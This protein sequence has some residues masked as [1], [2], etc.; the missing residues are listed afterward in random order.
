MTKIEA[1]IRGHLLEKVHHALEAI[2]VTG[3]TVSDV[4]GMGASKGVHYLYRGAEYTLTLNPRLKL[5]VI[6]NDSQVAEVVEAIQK[7]ASTGEV[8]D[9]KILTIPL[10]DVVRIR[11]GEKGELAL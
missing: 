9:G 6:V 7:A 4:R 10:G 5:E 11:T 2:Q 1:Y 8:G 3:M